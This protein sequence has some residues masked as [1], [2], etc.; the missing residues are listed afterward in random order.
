M[1]QVENWEFNSVELDFKDLKIITENA[2][3][4][5][6]CQNKWRE[7]RYKIEAKAYGIMCSKLGKFG[8]PFCLLAEKYGDLS[9]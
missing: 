2:K 9:P 7:K 1:L 8:H 6:V 3:K 4:D 5:R